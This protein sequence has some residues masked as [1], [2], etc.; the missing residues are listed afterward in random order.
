L[1]LEFTMSFEYHLRFF[2]LQSVIKSRK[3]VR[4]YQRTKIAKELAK[5]ALLDTIGHK[6]RGDEY[7]VEVDR[8][9]TLVRDGIVPVYDVRLC[10]TRGKSLQQL[11]GFYSHLRNVDIHGKW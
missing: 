1:Y 11:L 2:F 6:Y 3:C 4:S 9:Y 7:F 5:R 8:V 10:L